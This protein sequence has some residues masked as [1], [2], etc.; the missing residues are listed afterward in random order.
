MINEVELVKHGCF[1]LFFGIV[2]VVDKKI[3]PIDL[4]GGGGSIY[5][6]ESLNSKEVFALKAINSKK[7][8]DIFRELLVGEDIAKEC[9]NLVSYK[10]YFYID[11]DSQ[12][13]VICI[14][15]EYFEKGDFKKY[16]TKRFEKEDI[17]YSSV[18]V[19]V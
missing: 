17:F 11:I 9:Q 15:M 4:E 14:I 2:F 7:E 10:E 13:S 8:K 18:C 19:I 6:V 1:T 5:L 12:E 16:L 3:K